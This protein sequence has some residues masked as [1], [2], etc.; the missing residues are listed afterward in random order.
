[1][2]I[3]TIH[4]LAAEMIVYISED[5]IIFTLLNRLVLSSRNA[6]WTFGNYRSAP[7]RITLGKLNPTLFIYITIIPTSS[8][9]V[10]INI[11]SV[12]T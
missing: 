8:A 11:G 1:M 10:Y 4:L 5:K 2:E 9:C 3:M 7:S 6:I 12:E